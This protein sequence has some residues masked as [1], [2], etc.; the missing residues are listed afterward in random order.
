MPLW[1]SHCIF[2]FVSFTCLFLVPCLC[3]SVF[4]G[5]VLALL[6]ISACLKRE[7]K[8]LLSFLQWRSYFSLNFTTWFNPVFLTSW[9]QLAAFI[10]SFIL[11]SSN[12]YWT[13]C[14]PGSVHLQHL[15]KMSQMQPWRGLVREGGI[16]LNNYT[17]KY[18]EWEEIHEDYR[19]KAHFQ[20]VAES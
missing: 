20:E 13:H 16:L 9:V 17:C 8:L 7:K 5:C 4:K 18:V 12:I 1:V 6:C 15:V 3:V 2:V 19:G 10:F 14:V 11:G